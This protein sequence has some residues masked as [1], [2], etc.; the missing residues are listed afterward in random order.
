MDIS[1]L[2]KLYFIGVGGIGMSALA[3]LFR[4]DGVMVVGSD[5]GFADREG[6]ERSGVIVMDGYDESRIDESLDAVV[7]TLATPG[8]NE[9]LQ[10]ATKLKLPIFT[11]AEMLGKVS[12]LKDTIAVAGTHGKTTTT[13]MIAHMM[14]NASVNPSVIVGSLMR[15]PRDPTSRTNFIHGDSNY[16]VAESCEYKKSFL[17]INP[18]IL[19]ITNIDADHLDFYGNLENVIEAFKEFASKL[20]SDGVLV[21]D[22]DDVNSKPV[23]ESVKCKVV[24]WREF[25]NKDMKLMVYGDH[26]RCDAAVALAVASLVGIDIARAK[27]ALSTFSGTWRRFENKGVTSSGVMVFDDYGHHPHEIQATLNGAR[28]HFPNGQIAV[29]FEPHLFSRTREH[30]DEFVSVLSKFDRIYLL[31][32]YKAREEFD[33][34]ISS[35]MI[36]DE[37]RK[38]NQNAFFAHDYDEAKDLIEKDLSDGWVLITMGAGDITNLSSKLVNA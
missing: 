1:K 26:N 20:S 19:C 38:V 16:L 21:A 3:K 25:Y 10:K 28:E 29:A 24:N 13:A 12:S 32:I 15:D 17:N 23:I 8:D 22:F 35:Q 6:L 9:E 11:Y 7:Y 33:P 18:K 37:I 31:P 5:T 27:E 2:K 4:H 36:C 34:S 30:F 14:I